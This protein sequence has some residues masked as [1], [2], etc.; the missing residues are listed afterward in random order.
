MK[1]MEKRAMNRRLLWICVGYFLVLGLAFM[2]SFMPMVGRAVRTG[3]N[4]AVE[5]NES[6]YLAS[7]QPELFSS[8]W[9]EMPSASESVRLE[10]T[11]Y[12]GFVNIIVDAEAQP[13]LDAALALCDRA[14][15]TFDWLSMLSWIAILILT[16]LIINSLRKSVRDQQ[17]LPQGNITLMRIIGGLIIFDQL[18]VATSYALSHKMVRMA[19]SPEVAG[20]ASTF[21]TIEYGQVILG[22]LIL[23]AAEIFA[24]GSRLSEEQKLTI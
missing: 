7:V 19:A 8:P 4:L 24:L 14:I 3:Y 23:F 17:P 9:V 22:L 18:C 15:S 16:A 10:G 2:H 21:S 12:E 6:W 1:K 13:E 20:Y 11:L 5:H